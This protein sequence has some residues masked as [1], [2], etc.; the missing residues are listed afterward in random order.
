VLRSQ[1]WNA[2]Y[3]RE[4]SDLKRVWQHRRELEWH[5]ESVLALLAG[6]IMNRDI[7]K[8]PWAADTDNE[9]LC[10]LILCGLLN[11]PHFYQRAKGMRSSAEPYWSVLVHLILVALDRFADESVMNLFDMT[12][13]SFEN[14]PPEEVKQTILSRVLLRLRAEL[15]DVCV[16]DCARVR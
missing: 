13:K 4:E 1:F 3:F 2:Y 9:T 6:E 5:E 11:I 12:W 10:L 14:T 8:R 16:S 7:R 15:G